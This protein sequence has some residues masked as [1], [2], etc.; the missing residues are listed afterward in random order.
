MFGP[1]LIKALSCVW[2]LFSQ[3]SVLCLGLNSIKAQSL[4]R[5]YLIKAQSLFGP[6]SIKAQSL[7]RPY[8]I[9][10]QSLFG[11]YLIKAQSLFG[12]Y[13]IKAQSCVWTLFNQGSI[14]CL[15]LI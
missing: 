8:L 9:K 6:Y 2:A 5:P 4:F 10:A 14:L 12:P 15:G 7:F 13:L 1:Y 3:G 11:S